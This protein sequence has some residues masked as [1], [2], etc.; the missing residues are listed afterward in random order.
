MYLKP[1]Y[2]YENNIIKRWQIDEINGIKIQNRRL[3]RSSSN[4]FKFFINQNSLEKRK[5]YNKKIDDFHISDLYN[6]EN[7]DK[8]I[9]I[10]NAIVIYKMMIKVIIKN[11]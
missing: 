10:K 8:P 6:K 11:K 2:L 5:Y 3:F 7:L 1:N 9:T 4:I